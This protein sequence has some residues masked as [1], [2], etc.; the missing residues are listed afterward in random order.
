M[1]AIPARGPGLAPL[2]EAGTAFVRRRA[3]QVFGDGPVRPAGLAANIAFGAAVLG[4]THVE[5]ASAGAWQ[6]VASDFDWLGAAAGGRS[7]LFERITPFPEQGPG[8][9]RSEIYVSAFARRAYMVREGEVRWLV[10]G[11]DA[12]SGGELPHE[13]HVP[14]WCV[15]VLAFTFA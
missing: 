7:R 12:G 14:P 1:T 3:A 5:L 8:S 6:F 10:G 4:A 11:E 13:D 9:H 15:H 2:G